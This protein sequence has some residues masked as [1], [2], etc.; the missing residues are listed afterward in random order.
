MPRPSALGQLFSPRSVAVVGA[1]ADPKKLGNI[2]VRNIIDSGFAGPVYPVNP[3]GGAIR[4]LQ[5]FTRYADI[6]EPPDLAI[7]AI[8]AVAVADAL[9]Q[10]GRAGTNAC[11]VLSAGFKEVGEPGALLEAEL[12]EIA[13]EFGIALLGPNCLG[14]VNAAHPINATFGQLTRRPGTLRFMSQS[15]AIATSIFDWAD[16]TKLG[17]AEFVTLGNKAVISESDVLQ[18]WLRGR[19]DRTQTQKRKGYDPVGMYLESVV[20]GPMFLST[21]R[22]LALT[23]PVFVLKPGQ[24]EAAK[25]AMQSHTGALAGDHVVLQQALSEAGII[26]CRGLEDVFDLIRATAW[27]KAP[28]GNRVAVVSNAGGPAVLTSD[29][30]IAEGLEFA[31]L[32]ASTRRKLEQHLPRAASFQNPVDVLGD[33][34]ADRYAHALETVLEDSSVDAVVV[35]L[36]PQVMT[37]IEETAAVIAKL[38]AE[39]RQPIVCSFMGGSQISR[40]ERVL[41]EHE[42]A[43]FRYPERAVWALGRLWWWR[44]WQRRQRTGVVSAQVG[45]GSTSVLTQRKRSAIRTVITELKRQKQT[46]LNGDAVAKL[47]AKAGIA[48]PPA[49]VAKSLEEVQQ[50][51]TT[52][53]FPVVLKIS[54][55]HVLHKSDVGGVVTGIR[56]HQELVSA[57]WQLERIMEGLGRAVRSSGMIEVQKQIEGGVE[58]ILGI[59]RDPTFGP[60]LML[61]AG[62]VLAELIHEQNLQLLTVDPRQARQL[63]ETSKVYPL[64]A[65][66]RGGSRMA[67]GKLTQLVVQVAE[68]ALAVPELQEFEI[69]PVLVTRSEAWAVDGRGLLTDD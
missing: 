27:T 63:I 35:L 59:K 14:F 9:R 42:I 23:D 54:S 41:S 26:Q 19:A 68:L 2:V 17:F 34:L 18:H 39:Y 58:V 55:P 46:V 5:A 44:Q 15:G 56:T 3:H 52:H 33:A 1:S 69:N 36:T 29:R 16:Y 7:I 24:S 4:G 40:G 20:D 53:H 47:F 67:I 50:F 51:V 49:V 61:G 12:A 10:V 28:T 62:G 13:Q 57:Y 38:A 30:V 45:T 66:Y 60:V 8:P 6:P 43:S 32:S 64:L 11:V 48:Q 65:G 25:S 31:E 21:A 22:Q 37:Q